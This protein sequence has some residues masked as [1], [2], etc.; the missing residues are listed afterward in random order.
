MKGIAIREKFAIFIIILTLFLFI[1]IFRFSWIPIF[2][3]IL[4]PVVINNRALNI[5]WVDMWNKVTFHIFILRLNIISPNWDRVDM[6]TIFLA[7]NSFQ[8]DKPANIDVAI[9]EDI[10]KLLINL[11]FEIRLNRDSK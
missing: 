11:L 10:I 3:T 5:A 8:A 2:I 1:I 6:A 4:N 9:D 7:S